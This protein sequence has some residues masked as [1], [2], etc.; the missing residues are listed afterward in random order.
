MKFNIIE[1]AWTWITI[2]F[3]VN[4]FYTGYVITGG[5]DSSKLPDSV[6]Y[7]L[8]MSE[9]GTYAT[10]TN[11][12]QSL[13]LKEGGGNYTA[14]DINNQQTGVIGYILDVVDG[15]VNFVR[16]IAFA[17][18]FIGFGGLFIGWMFWGLFEGWLGLIAGIFMIFGNIIFLIMIVQ[19]IM[20]KFRF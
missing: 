12:L 6:I 14:S 9:Q 11:S 18:G 2:M 17:V 8:F 10:N 20:N 1:Y 5:Y 15:L 13:T 16:W 19:L 7:T 3:I 4:I